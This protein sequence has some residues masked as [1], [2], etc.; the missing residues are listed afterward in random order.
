MVVPISYYHPVQLMTILYLQV[1]EGLP[2]VIYLETERED[3]GSTAVIT[4][5]S[6][7]RK[8]EIATIKI[9]TATVAILP[10]NGRYIISV[11]APGYKP[12]SEIF[13]MKCQIYRPATC[14]HALVM[15]AEV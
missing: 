10:E 15:K 13:N 8:N 7:N 12:I 5:I 4:V 2:L 6:D 11:I 3:I 9:G 14:S 1:T